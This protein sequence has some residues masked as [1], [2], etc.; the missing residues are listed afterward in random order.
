M[1]TA[2]PSATIVASPAPSAPPKGRGAYLWGTGRRKSSVARVRLAPGDGKFQINGR[3]V[4]KYFT[5][6]LDRNDVLAPL[7]STGAAGKWN[8]V[9]RVHGGGHTGQAGAIKLGVARALVQANP[10]FEPTLRDN[11][12]LTRDAREVE[13]KKYGRRKARR[14]FQFS[15]R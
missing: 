2:A 12:Y 5:E 10:E 8:I 1:T 11:G 3:N 6:P 4:E 7:V 14:R 13:R 15:K 9:V